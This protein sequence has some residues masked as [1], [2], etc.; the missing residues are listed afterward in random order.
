[1]SNIQANAAYHLRVLVRVALAM[2]IL[3]GT[4]LL[5]DLPAAAKSRPASNPSSPRPTAT[6]DAAPIY[7]I[8]IATLS[9]KTNAESM[10]KTLTKLGYEAYLEPVPGADGEYRIK[11]GKY[12]D[13]SDVHPVMARLRKDGFPSVIAQH[14][15][16]AWP[17]TEVET[18]SLP[19]SSA[20]ADGPASPAPLASGVEP[21]LAPAEEKTNS[22][23]KTVSSKDSAV[24]AGGHAVKKTQ[25]E[26]T[27][28]APAPVTEDYWASGGPKIFQ[29]V[30]ALAFVLTLIAGAYLLVKRLNPERL[31]KRSKERL[32]LAL[33]S[34][35]VGDKKSLMLVEVSGDKYL[36]A[37]TPNDV[38]LLAKI[39]S[40]TPPWRSMAAPVEPAPAS[41]DFA[42]LLSLKKAELS[43]V[44]GVG[45]KMREQGKTIGL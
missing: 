14:K 20:T 1:M 19:V 18:A 5:W 4:G 9:K 45:A 32:M 25:E 29:V 8:Q 7:S 31:G 28:E 39:E 10:F 36:L 13:L 23:Q 22:A 11:V 12:N 38:C 40:A 21:A 30:G 24:G 43:R 44:G 27:A 3:L 17:N 35:T 6:A 16:V 41:P 33:D 34:M 15:E 26:A 37:S 2:I 42:T